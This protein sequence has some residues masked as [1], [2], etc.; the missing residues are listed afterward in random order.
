MKGKAP[1]AIFY[2][3]MDATGG[4]MLKQAR[5]LGIKSVFSFGDGACTAEMSKLAGAAAEGMICS[6]AGL[7]VEA[8]SKAFVTAFNAKYGEIKQYAPF[9]YDAANLL[10]AAM[11]KADSTDP[12]KYLPALQSISYDG[13]TGHI[14]FDDKGDRKNAEITIFTLKD[15]KVVPIAVVKGGKAQ[16]FDDFMKVASAAPAPAP[17]AAAPMAPAPEPKK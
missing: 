3:G 11:Q 10:I 12:A 16:S 5:E 14:E 13:A 17:A 9:T 4:P 2:G 8:A 15:G 6:Q 1:D 7:P